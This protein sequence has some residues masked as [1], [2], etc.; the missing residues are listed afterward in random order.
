MLKVVFP[1]R[2]C[3]HVTGAL[4]IVT[5][6]AVGRF[7]GVKKNHCT[8]EICVTCD[9]RIF[10]TMRKCAVPRELPDCMQSNQ[11]RNSVVAL[12]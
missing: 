3:F 12:F 2:F 9:S 8:V 1:V 11:T 6:K 4:S 10:L 7:V 5:K